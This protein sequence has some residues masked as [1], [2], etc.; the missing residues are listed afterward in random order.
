[1]CRHFSLHLH[2]GPRHVLGE[3]H[4]AGRGACVNASLRG[5]KHAAPIPC[6]GSKHA[7]GGGQRSSRKG[8]GAME[9]KGQRQQDAA[10]QVYTQPK[11]SDKPHLSTTKCCAK[12]G[13]IKFQNWGPNKMAGRKCT[14]AEA[15]DPRPK[16]RKIS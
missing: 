14:H 12:C 9:S 7:Q 5:A 4:A 2:A 15:I 11:P 1:M 8:R 16:H 10:V 6:S 3:D 13:T